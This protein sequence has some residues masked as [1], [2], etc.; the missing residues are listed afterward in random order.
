MKFLMK[1]EKFGDVSLHFEIWKFSKFEV[2]NLAFNH[3]LISAS[4]AKPK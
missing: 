4:Y 1:Y 3:Y 2:Q